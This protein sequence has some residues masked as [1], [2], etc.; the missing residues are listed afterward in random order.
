MTHARLDAFLQSEGI[1]FFSARELCTVR[2]IGV[3]CDPPPE[4]WWPRIIPTLRY[5]EELRA[6]IGLPLS[7]GSAWRPADVNKRVGG[8]PKSQHVHFRA[9]DLDLPASQRLARRDEFNAMALHIYRRND[10]LSGLGF[11]AS[12]RVHLD[13]RPGS[14]AIWGSRLAAA[15]A[16]AK[17]YRAAG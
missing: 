5:A 1:R 15:Q 17:R 12:G 14:R 10:G 6:A 3:L 7:V 8:A 16:A 9:V 13:T 4:A 2:S 11:Y